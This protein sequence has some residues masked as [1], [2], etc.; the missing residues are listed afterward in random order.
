M[1]RLSGAGHFV[2]DGVVSNEDLAEIMETSNEWVVQRSG[3]RSRHWVRHILGKS[4][5]LGN[6]DLAERASRQALK[7]AEILPSQIGAIVYA[8]ITPDYEWPGSGSLLAERINPGIPAY[9]VRNHCTGFLYGLLVARTMVDSSRFEHVLLVGVEILSTGLDV[10]TRGRN[11]AVLFADG[12]GA[13]VVSQSAEPGI[14]DLIL[15]TDGRF[16]DKLGVEAPSFARPIPLKADDFEGEAPAVFPRMEGKLVFKHASE[17]MPEM[18]QRVL[19][20]SGFTANDLRWIVPH[21]A[22][23]RI[24]DMLGSA[25]GCP[26]KV[27]SNIERFGNTTAA[28]IPICLSEIQTQGKLDPGDLLCL[29]SFGAGFAWGAAVLRW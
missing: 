13:V 28:T 15:E 14:Y 2:P 1:A 17:K 22:N 20:K 29:V 24:I 26:G 19:K 4:D 23:Q 21:Q 5:I 6:V 16:A 8:T 3:I 25:L 7:R 27:Y 10:S 9:E 18:V 11:T 12:A